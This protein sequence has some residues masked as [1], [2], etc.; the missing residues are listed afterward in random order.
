MIKITVMWMI[1]RSIFSSAWLAISQKKWQALAI[2]QKFVDNFNGHISEVI[3]LEAPDG[4]IYNIQAIRDLNKIVLGSG[5]GVFVSF[6]KLKAGYFL[7]F[8][9]IR[10]SHFKVL[11]FDFGTC[12]E[13]EVFHVLMNCGPDSQEKES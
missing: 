3:K 13:K 4:N 8:R 6:Y 5:W 1:P 7:V 2:P 10:D 9:Y 11:I 12:C